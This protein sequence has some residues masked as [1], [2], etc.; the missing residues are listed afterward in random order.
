MGRR[1]LPLPVRYLLACA[2]LL[3]LYAVAPVR[4]EADPGLLVL[5]WSLTL[6]L[7]GAIALVIGR[8]AVRQLRSPDAP[9]GA[10]VVCVVAGLLLFALMDFGLAVNREGQF[11]GLDTRVDALYFALSTLLT[12]GFGDVSAQGQA[13]RVLLIAQMAFNIT[14]IAGAASLVTRRVAA[15]AAKSDRHLRTRHGR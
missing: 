6:F 5:R 8:E 7:V 9:I 1:R 11:T 13:A 3:A 10:L 4:P 2:G 14:A 15:R 12:V